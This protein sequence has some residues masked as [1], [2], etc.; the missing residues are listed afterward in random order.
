MVAL[1]AAAAVIEAGRQAAL[2]APTE[3][4]ARQHYA[5]IAPLA[6]AAAIEVATHGPRTR[7]GAPRGLAR[8]A[9]G[10]V[11]L[12]VGTH[13][14]FQEEVIFQEPRAGGRRR[15]APFR[16]APTARFRAKGR[17]RRGAGAHRDADPAHTGA[18]LF[19]DMDVSQLR[20]NP[21]GRQPID[22]RTS[23]YPGWKKSSPR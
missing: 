17:S 20:E 5:T 1:L 3:L 6:A 7:P 15:A 23:L 12:V 18:E 4:L 2:M 10:Q 22:T 9:A 13:A 19:G 8:L 21:A 16:C 14:L 11:H